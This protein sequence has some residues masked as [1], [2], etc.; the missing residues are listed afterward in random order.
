V[1]VER[2]GRRVDAVAQVTKLGNTLLLDRVTGE[3]LY[4][5]RFVRVD[6]H[7]LPGDT[8][9]AYQPAPEI[10]PPFARQAYTRADMPTQPEAR[11]ALLPLVE[12]AN[13]GP[14][15]SFDEARPTLLFNIHGGA[16]WTGAAAD[17]KGFLYVTSNEIPW[18]ITCFRD[19]DPAPLV[20]A[21]AGELVYQTHCAACHGPERKGVGHAPP[22]RGLRHRL[23]EADIRAV[24]KT[25]RASMPPM[26]HLTETQLQP[27]LE[28]LLCKDRPATEV[29]AQNGR[30]WT[31]SGFNRVLDASGY[32]ACS[33]PWGTLNCI[34][35][36][37]GKIAWR[38][39]LG[40]YPELSAQGIPK[41][42][43]EN[44]GGATVTASGL[45]FASGTRDKQI[46][47]FDAATG[48][49]LWSHT[50]PLHGTAPS[51]IYE[52]E[53]RQFILQPA[54]GGGKLGG[55]AGDAWVAFALP[56]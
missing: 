6:T 1:S 31:F 55:P 8:T 28:F 30:E 16:E 5:F 17:P 20:P 37:T 11:A 41:T 50:M 48:E 49:E 15:P 24:L 14:F 22:L 23:A 33:A 2:H 12:R 18:S 13:L 38:V 3:P 10:P 51:T 47:A 40:E 27:L 45:V 19:D 36:N 26:A 43:Q 52:A 25:G 34:D 4:D 56:K 44:F 21:G 35:L 54:T 7:A 32:P 29:P 53:G 9:A 42:G 46:R 39:P